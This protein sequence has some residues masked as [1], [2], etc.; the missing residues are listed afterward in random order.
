MRNRTQFRRHAV[1]PEPGIQPPRQARRFITIHHISSQFRIHAGRRTG[2]PRNSAPSLEFKT[3]PIPIF[4]HYSRGCRTFTSRSTNS[5]PNRLCGA[6][7]R[8]DGNHRG[9]WEIGFGL[10]SWCCGHIARTATFF[11]RSSRRLRGCARSNSGNLALLLYFR[12]EQGC[13]RRQSGT[14]IPPSGGANPHI[15]GISTPNSTSSTPSS[16]ALNRTLR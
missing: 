15:S 16:G 5:K 2:A 12:S 1:P 13:R 11:V 14:R 9:A 4:G 8:V 7:S 3:K 6:D 10:Y